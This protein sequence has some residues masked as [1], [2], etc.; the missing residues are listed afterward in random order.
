MKRNV[1]NFYIL[2]GV[3]IRII[4]TSVFFLL[5][6]KVQYKEYSNEEIMEKATELGM[7]TIKES[8][9]TNNEKNIKEEEIQKEMKFSIKS[10][11]QLVEIANN[12]FESGI[13]EDK[14][15]FIQFIEDK[16]MDKRLR[17]GDYVLNRNLSYTTIMKILS[18]N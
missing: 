8:L 11:Q 13:I 14:Q 15:E 4:I 12:L 16:K 3:G 10:G 5:N 6:P 7:V 1:Y 17:P 9:S 18:K 2:L